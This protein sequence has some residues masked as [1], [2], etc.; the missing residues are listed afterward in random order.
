MAIYTVTS[1]RGG[2]VKSLGLPLSFLVS[3]ILDLEQN[4]QTERLV[5]HTVGF[6]SV[7]E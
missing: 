2:W 1:E 4:S 3:Y 5:F 6:R 7:G